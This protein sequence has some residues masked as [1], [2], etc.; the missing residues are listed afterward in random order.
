MM[1][2][3]MRRRNFFA[4][5]LAAFAPAAAAVT[6]SSNNMIYASGDGVPHTPDEYAQLLASLTKDGKV[7]RDSYS[8]GGVVE[9]LESRMASVLGKGSRGLASDRH[10]G[11]S[12]CCANAGGQSSTG[13]GTSGKPSLQ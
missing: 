3:I 2:L 10:A 13:A 12:S 4:T 11:Q 9:E 6:G 5:P 1:Q 8:L 7:K